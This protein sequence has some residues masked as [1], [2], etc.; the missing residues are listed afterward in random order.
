MYVS[1]LITD[2]V[3]MIIPEMYYD[4]SRDVQKHPELQLVKTKIPN[5]Y[6]GASID[7]AVQHYTLLI[8]P[9][10]VKEI[11]VTGIFIT[12]NW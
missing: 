12:I 3:C 8:A 1:S 4:H 2:K 5:D 7:V 11:T 6:T 9:Q 10:H